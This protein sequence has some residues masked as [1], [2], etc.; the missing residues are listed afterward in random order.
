[1]VRGR[2][3]GWKDV[4]QTSSSSK[5]AK[6]NAS[7]ASHRVQSSHHSTQASGAMSSSTQYITVANVPMTITCDDSHGADSQSDFEHISFPPNAQVPISSTLVDLS[8]TLLEYQDP[9]YEAAT[10][11]NVPFK[12]P[13]DKKAAVCIVL[14]CLRRSDHIVGLSAFAVDPEAQTFP[15]RKHPT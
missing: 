3:D 13:R 10:R 8:E 15:F 7:H 12:K 1:M 14:A 4:E 5:K 2:K 6:V 9:Q 11:D